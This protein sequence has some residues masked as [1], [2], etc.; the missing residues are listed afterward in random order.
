MN[1]TIDTGPDMMSSR[2]QGGPRWRAYRAPGIEL[3]ETRALG[4]QGIECWGF[5]WPAV[6]ANVRVPQVVCQQ[7]HNIRLLYWLCWKPRLW[8]QADEC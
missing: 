2:H 4:G 1:P 6:A 8:K 7:Y 5:D 3:A